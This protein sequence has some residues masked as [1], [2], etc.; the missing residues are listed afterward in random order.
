MVVISDPGKRMNGTILRP[1]KRQLNLDNLNRRRKKGSLQAPPPSHA[2]QWEQI[3]TFKSIWLAAGL[4]YKKGAGKTEIKSEDGP[5]GCMER[6]TSVGQ[7]RGLGISNRRR[8]YRAVPVESLTSYVTYQN[9]H[10]THLRA[11]V[12]KIN[13]LSKD[14]RRMV[15]FNHMA[16]QMWR[17]N[18]QL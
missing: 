18:P 13:E 6:I 14:D 3:A 1:T 9:E 7:C 17:I 11:S 5:R 4:E 16:H 2:A 15:K 12:N 10:I 8:L